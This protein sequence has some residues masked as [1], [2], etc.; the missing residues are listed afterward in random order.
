MFSA[1][2]QAPQTVCPRLKANIWK[3]FADADNWYGFMI[4]KIISA[5]LAGAMW[6]TC[7]MPCLTGCS[8]GQ[9]DGYTVAQWLDKVEND[10]NMLYYTESEPYF[11]SVTSE[12]EDFDTVQIAAEWGLIDTDQGIK[13]ADKITKE[14]AAQTLVAA[15]AFDYEVDAGISDADKISDVHSASI[16]VNEGVFAL[17]SNGKFDPQK[18][19]TKEEADEAASIAR[20]KWVNLSYTESYNKSEVKDGVINLG[21]ISS[22]LAEVAPAQYT[23][24]YSGDLNVIDEDG[25]YV[26]NSTKTITFP[27]GT[28]IGV[29]VGSVLTLPADSQTPTAFAVV[30]DSI[31]ENSDGSMT[32]TTHN[33]ELE[34]VYENVDIQISGDDFSLENAVVYDMQGNCISGGVESDN[35]SY[36]GGST[37]ISSNGGYEKDY[38]ADE[39]K[40]GKSG[41]LQIG[42]KVTVNYSF[43]GK[44]VTFSIDADVGDD[45]AV[46]FEKEISIEPDAKVKLFD[47]YARVSI[48][49]DDVLSGKFSYSHNFSADNG[50]T[51]IMDDGSLS[52]DDLSSFY[53]VV[54]SAIGVLEEDANEAAGELSVP[55]FKFIIPVVYVADVEFI[56]R[57]NLSVS[58][59]ISFKVETSATYGAEYAKGKLRAIND[60]SHSKELDMEAKAELRLYL[61]AGVG[62]LGSTV[63]DA[64]VNLGVGAKVSTKF[65]QIEKASGAITQRCALPTGM[66]GGNQENSTELSL[67]LDEDMRGCIDFIAY[68]IV[69]LELCSSQCKINKLGWVKTYTLE[70]SGEDNPFYTFHYETD[71]GV[72]DSCTRESGDILAI[73]EGNDLTLNKDTVNIAVGESY[74]KVAVSTLP[75][76]YTAKDLVFEI[77]DGAIASV[78]NLID[79][80]IDGFEGIEG[81]NSTIFKIPIFSNGDGSVDYSEIQYKKYS[82]NSAKHS[83]I[84]GAADGTTVLTVSTKDGFYSAQ[85]TIMVGNGGIKER[86][87]NAFV[88]DTYS[89]KLTPGARGQIIVSAAPDGYDMNQVTFTSNDTSVA[90]VSSSGVVTAVGDGQT[91]ITISTTDGA[92]TAMCMVFVS[93]GY[94]VSEYESDGG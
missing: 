15:M 34:E 39:I 67:Q 61:G 29:E 16:A 72:V 58:G 47:R 5:I 49:I 41:S 37:V 70:V 43:K 44:K 27:S 22:D 74:T 81:I 77:E 63:I 94:A 26:D 11:A 91:T 32:V 84:F 6:L 30:V 4:K 86:T 69:E 66:F 73:A 33:A 40:K 56:V 78:V 80:S 75:K 71:N 28:N 62:F 46:K 87:A 2:R 93:S 17:D 13:L 59:E 60:F 21:G 68:P 36:A 42:K 50:L 88:I 18:K 8:G 64:G 53:D 85:C 9:S 35:V 12:S 7:V 10:F 57:L 20:D 92:Y 31:T 89:L 45:V 55:L 3:G 38:L 19:L 14:Y 52:G 51:A 24:E 25:N 1:K 83:M 90:T 54:S 48:D 79:G 82:S 65:Y 23:I 76:G